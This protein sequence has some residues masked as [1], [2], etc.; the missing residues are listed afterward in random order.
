MKRDMD[1]VR[2]ILLALEAHPEPWDWFE[3]KIDGHSD[4]E[5][6]YH[7]KLMSQ[8][9]LI[10]ASERKRP[11]IFQWIPHSLTWAGHEFLEAAR[12]NSRW[13]KVKRLAWEK[14]GSLPFEVLKAGLVKEMLRLI[15]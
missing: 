15:S 8:A 5:V 3:L 9:G 2:K 12:D 14:T 10:E 7:L 11:D 6:S 4:V 13:E 1:L